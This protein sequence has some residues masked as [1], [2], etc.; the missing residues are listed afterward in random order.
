[1]PTSPSH[2]VLRPHGV[3]IITDPALNREIHM[4]AMSCVHCQELWVVV[5]GSGKTRG[6]C[7]KC[8]GPICGEKC[9]E[10][11]GPW[12]KRMERIEAGIV[13]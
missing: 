11:T 1:M 4:D 7:L 3:I 6:F 9:A 12:E 2:S 10:C 8:M 13:R 5:P